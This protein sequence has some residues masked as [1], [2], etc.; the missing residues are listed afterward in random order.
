MPKPADAGGAGTGGQGTSGSAGS[1]GATGAATGGAEPISGA[2][3]SVT[4]LAGMSTGG[5]SAVSPLPDEARAGSGSKMLGECAC[6]AAH[7]RGGWRTLATLL[8]GVGVLFARRQR[9]PC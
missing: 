2:G 7:G 4:G 1:G 9:A 3:T 5:A 8:L 6:R